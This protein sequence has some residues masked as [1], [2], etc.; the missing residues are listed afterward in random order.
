MPLEN[1][2][3][4]IVLLPT[5]AEKEKRERKP[6]FTEEEFGTLVNEV[7]L[8]NVVLMLKFQNCVTI[9]QILIQGFL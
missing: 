3:L 9:S 6:S 2:A 4:N 8:E 7:A 1:S 5:M